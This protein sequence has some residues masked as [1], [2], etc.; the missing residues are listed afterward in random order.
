MA[1]Y[2]DIR[3]Y[4]QTLEERGKLF[5][6][7]SQVNKDTQMHPLVRLQFRGL[8]EEQRKAFLFE[9]I[10]DSRGRQYS[11]P[12][13]VAALAGSSQIFALG[14]MCKPGE[15]GEKFDQARL[16]PI[17]PVIVNNGPAYEEVHTGDSLLEHGGLT[18]F[19]FLFPRQ[20]MM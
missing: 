18:S 5:R 16:H 7:K 20:A 14:M 2:K 9:N 6:I 8:P 4:L 17:E 13:L 19:L 11:S 15:I 3:E 12:T 1:Y 10:I